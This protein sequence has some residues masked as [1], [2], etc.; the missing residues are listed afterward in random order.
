MAR[1]GQARSTLPTT[2]EPSNPIAVCCNF[3]ARLF[4]SFPWSQ[5]SFFLIAGSVLC[6][7]WRKWSKSATLA[8]FLTTKLSNPIAVQ[9]LLKDL[10][11]RVGEPSP[12]KNISQAGSGSAERLENDYFPAGRPNNS[13]T[14]LKATSDIADCLYLLSHASS[15]CRWS[16]FAKSLCVGSSKI[17]FGPPIPTT[18]HLPQHDG[19]R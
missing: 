11:L 14:T 13:T 2:T 3:L 15:Q 9:P 18:T 16:V 10:F 6:Q 19:F 7:F 4:S 12:S 1:V 8:A 5:K 17:S